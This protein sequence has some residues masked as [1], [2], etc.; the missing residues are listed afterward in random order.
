MSRAADLTAPGA[1]GS[2]VPVAHTVVD[3][4]AETPTTVTL[5]VRP[6][7]GEP[8]PFAAG[9]VSML[10]AFG[11]GEVP[12]SI[13]SDPGNPAVQWYTI[14]RAGAVTAALCDLRPG[15]VLGVRG[16]F[17]VPWPLRGAAGGDALIMAGGIGLAPL[18]SAVVDVLARRRD[19][20]RATVLYG[21]KSPSELVFGTDLRAWRDRLDLELAVTVDTPDSGWVGATG[22]VTDLIPADLDPRRTTALLCGPEAMMRATLDALATRGLPPTRIWV[23]M[24]RNMLCGVGL[25]GHCQ[26][27][28]F[29]VCVHGPVLRA[30]RVAPYLEVAQL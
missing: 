16:P 23:S 26:L 9:Q 7:A 17:G 20:R 29:L 4:W 15:D 11:V 13:S 19:F 14:R 24:E 3:A 5:A 2:M 27:G 6:E 28:P 18:R 8:V 1:V 10:Y 22:L 12:I 21:A 25:C 30:D